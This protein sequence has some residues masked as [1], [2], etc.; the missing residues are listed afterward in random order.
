MANEAKIKELVKKR[1]SI[2]A[3]LTQ[4]ISF[5]ANAKSYEH[6]SDTQ[7]LEL[8]LRLRKLESSYSAYD[9]FQ[10]ELEIISDSPEEL[11]ADREQFESQYY[12]QTAAARNLIA[13][14]RKLSQQRSD[15]ASEVGS[16]DNPT[17]VV[18]NSRQNNVRLP[19]INLPHFSGGYQDWLEFKDI[20]VSLI[21]NDKA[22]DEINKFHYL[23]TS[24][25]GSAALIIRSLDFTAENYRNAW[26][27]LCER[28][29]NK[30]L[31]VNNHV[32][33][34]FSVNAIQRESSHGIRNIVDVT[35]K[36]LRALQTLKQ[37]VEHWD[38]LIIFIMASKLDSVTSRHWEEHRNTL[39]DTPKLDAFIQFLRNRA[40]LLE[41]LEESRSNKE[42]NISNN[43]QKSFVVLPNNNNS[44]LNKMQSYV[45]PLCNNNHFIFNCDTFKSLPVQSRISK[46]KECKVCLNCLRPG[47]SYTKCKL[48]HCKYCKTKHNTLLHSHDDAPTL[49]HVA[50]SANNDSYSSRHVL[51]ST[52]LVKVLGADGR[53]QH[54]RVLLDN[55]STA[56]FV[57][58][59]LIGKLKL[60]MQISTRNINSMQRFQRVE[61]LRQHF[62]RRFSNEYIFW[63]QNKT[64]WHSS[65]GEL[66]EGA[67]VVIKEKNT[68]P[69]MWLLG[70]IERVVPGND[71]VA[72]VADIRT[73]KGVIRRAFNS[74]CCLPISSLEDKSSTPGVC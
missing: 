15:S 11:Y 19:K 31:L 7:L 9:E 72:R 48:S 64:K 59:S 61:S 54:A 4:F 26:S 35:N 55:G 6:L 71:G 60:P 14:N 44:N 10:S 33:S 69:L 12:S 41:T 50:L 53:E 58:Q 65:K 51:L 73:K 1:A 66:V 23:R 34:L 68:P 62:W 22:I 24:L 2:K 63:L 36:N 70:R 37:P 45:C 29:D 47:H 5:L 74:I 43:K 8:E 38:T 20:Y 67:L 49:E 42:V 56:N 18:Q 28:Y 21:H 25:H 32:K 17:L 27:L 39:T 57:T 30:Q 40:N 16:G 52:A 13:V 46:A 3:K